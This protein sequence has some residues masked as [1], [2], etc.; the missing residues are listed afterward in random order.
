VPAEG[1]PEYRALDSDDLCVLNRDGLIAI[2]SHTITHPALKYESGEDQMR[3]ILG[4]KLTLETILKHDVTSFSYPFGGKGDFSKETENFVKYAGYTIACANY[5]GMVTR[6]TDQ[7]RLPRFLVRNW[8]PEIF[9]QKIS[10]W[11]NG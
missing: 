11:F 3:E 1:R 2:G 7:Y 4:S 8:R 9:A 5:S 6:W 10:E